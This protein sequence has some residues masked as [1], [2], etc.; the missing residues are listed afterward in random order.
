MAR[1]SILTVEPS[2][3]FQ[4]MERLRSLPGDI[5]DA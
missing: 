2:R 3:G 5:A 4:A 1:W